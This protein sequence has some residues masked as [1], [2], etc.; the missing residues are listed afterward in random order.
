MSRS[1]RLRFISADYEHNELQFL[2][3]RQVYTLGLGI[4]AL[5]GTPTRLDFLAGA[6]YT[7]ESYNP[8]PTNNMFGATIGQD[9]THRFGSNT[10]LTEQLIVYPNLQDVGEYRAAFDMRFATKLKSWLSWLTTVSDRYTSTPLPGTKS[11]DVIF[12]TGLN[13][14]FTH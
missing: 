5:R 4:H 14:T 11:N 1:T 2:D 8:T 9:L 12:T 10:V 6:N 3:L 7:M 13:I